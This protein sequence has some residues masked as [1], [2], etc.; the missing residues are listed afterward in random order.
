MEKTAEIQL[1]SLS[2]TLIRRSTRRTVAL[3]VKSDNRIVVLAP[4][5]ASASSVIAFVKRSEPWVQ[6]RITANT[7]KTA[8]IPVLH[9]VAGDIVHYLGRPYELVEGT[10]ATLRMKDTTIII[11]NTSASEIHR[12]L[13]RWYK[14][15]AAD[16]FLDRL[17][18]YEPRVGQQH[19]KLRLS[20]AK[21]RWGSC[22]TTGTISLR[23]TLIMAPLSVIDYVVV[24]ELCHLV[25]MDHSRSF[26]K[27]VKSIYPDYHA[28]VQWLKLHGQT[29][30]L[31][32]PKKML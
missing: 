11:P 6:K 27:L 23:W 21:T 12:K 1:E 22:T 24:H 2:F 32:N 4:Y 7:V 16:I 13:N 28:A 15:R 25:H 10:L 17:S 29:L 26:W 19:A 14:T 31:P 9:Y 18:L 8:Q 30:A 20:S 3:S 5:F